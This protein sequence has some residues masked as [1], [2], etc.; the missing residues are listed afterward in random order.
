MEINR[1]YDV[2]VTYHIL[3]AREVDAMDKISAE[4]NFQRPY[5]KKKI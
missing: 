3:S 1:L 4:C 2:D 5:I